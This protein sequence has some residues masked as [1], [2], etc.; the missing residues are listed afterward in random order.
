MTSLAFTLGVLPLAIA[1]GAGAGGQNEIGIA[2]IGGMIS[3]TVLAIVFVPLFFVLIARR[4][5]PPEGHGEEPVVAV[6]PGADEEEAAPAAAATRAAR[7][8]AHA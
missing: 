6:E 7:E 1:T 4:S 8:A 3:A 2:V 5:T